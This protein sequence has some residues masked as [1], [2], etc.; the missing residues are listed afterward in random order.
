MDAWLVVFIKQTP[1]TGV[2]GVVHAVLA[3]FTGAL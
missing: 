2:F 1:S 3:L